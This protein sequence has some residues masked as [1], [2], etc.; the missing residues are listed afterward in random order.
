M[1][2]KTF[3]LAALEQVMAHIGFRIIF[4]AAIP[5]LEATITDVTAFWLLVKFKR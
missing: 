4:A 2:N 1:Q 5:G 3:L